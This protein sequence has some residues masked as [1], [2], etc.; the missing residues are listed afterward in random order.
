MMA[1]NAM[2]PSLPCDAI[3]SDY[4]ERAAAHFRG[5]GFLRFA[6]AELVR[7]LPGFCTVQMQCREDMTGEPRRFH[8]GVIGAL[9][10][11]A[12]EC[13]ALSLLPPDSSLAA[14]D[15]SAHLLAPAE[16]DVLVVQAK[17]VKSARTMTLC[18]AE[19]YVRKDQSH[20][21]CAMALVTYA[22]G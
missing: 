19:I 10:V 7:L 16:G 4:E 5:Q 17:V 18:T 21:L 12:G 6:G 13:A 15:Y 11:S 9:A 8:P 14:I 1:G 3:D 22:S 20:N 2:N